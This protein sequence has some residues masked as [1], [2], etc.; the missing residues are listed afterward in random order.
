MRKANKLPLSQ[1]LYSTY[2]YQGTDGAVLTGNPDIKNRYYNEL[3]MLRCN[4][5]FLWGYTSPEVTVIGTSW[6][7]NPHLD[8]KVISSQYLGGYINYAIPA[9][10]DDGYYVAFENV[11]DYYVEGKTW[12]KENHF[13]HD[14]LIFGYDFEKN[15]YDVFAYDSKWIY[16]PFETTRKAFDAGRRSMLKDGI[17]TNIIGVKPTDIKVEFNFPLM[18]ENLSKY[19][20]S[21][22]EKY[23]PSERRENAYGIIVHE[24]IAMY[25]Q[26]LIEGSIP[27]ARMDRRIFR[28]IWEHKCVM[29]KRIEL[30]EE[31][32]KIENEL[33]RRYKNIVAE[34]ENMRLL[35]AS[36]HMKRRDPLLNIIIKKLKW[37][38][39]EEKELL[40]TLVDLMEVKLK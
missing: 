14:G 5:R 13:K 1:P 8:K 31:F 21:S 10:I 26:K 37:I 11:D 34:A 19:L 33:S 25:L 4:R 17:Y 22:F 23:P 20:D 29:L 6:W 32:L 30:A 24:Y 3:M 9:F 35:Y 36:Y 38:M 28:L 27:Y 40:E 2:H 16:Q 39:T 12:Y 7:D 15:T 18:L